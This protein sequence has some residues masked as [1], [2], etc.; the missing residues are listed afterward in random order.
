ML[1]VPRPEQWSASLAQSHLHREEVGTHEAPTAP[2]SV[3]PGCAQADTALGPLSSSQSRSHVVPTPGPSAAQLCR[4][5]RSEDAA[6]LC[7]LQ[8]TASE[9]PEAERKDWG[10]EELLPDPGLRGYKARPVP[11]HP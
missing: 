9:E 2:G 4:M 11:T 10:P 6:Q 3:Y 5:L 1:G 8:T 7:S